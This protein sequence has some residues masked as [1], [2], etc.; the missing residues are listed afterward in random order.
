M[1]MNRHWMGGMMDP[2][3]RF[4]AALASDQRLKIL[5]LLKEGEKSSAD[6]NEA[7]EIDSSVVSR[8]LMLLRNVGLVKARKEG[9]MLYFAVADESVYELVKIATDIIQK[10]LD[11]N[12]DF[13]QV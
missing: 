12:R 6:L 2:R 13:I 3:S 4:F 11:Q 7:M 8:H 1:G 10:W 5:S 9:V